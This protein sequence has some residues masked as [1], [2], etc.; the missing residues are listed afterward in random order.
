MTDLAVMVTVH[1]VD[2]Q[3]NTQPND[4]SHPVFRWKREHECNAQEYSEGRNDRRTRALEGSVSSWIDHAEDQ[5]RC[6]YESECEESPDAGQIRK[7]IERQKA[8]T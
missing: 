5:D 7:D 4:E 8:R 3:P 6:A 2:R 1:E